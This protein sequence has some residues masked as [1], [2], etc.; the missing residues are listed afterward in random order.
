MMVLNDPFAEAH[1][2]DRREFYRSRGATTLGVR[3]LV[4]LTCWR[5]CRV[6]SLS[7]IPAPVHVACSRD[8]CPPDTLEEYEDYVIVNG[9][10]C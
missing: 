8:V 6:L 2:L 4:G 10:C 5:A 1:L 3:E 9:R 7:G